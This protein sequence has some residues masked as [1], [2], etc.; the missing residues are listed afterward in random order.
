MRR[1]FSAF[2][3]V[4]KVWATRSQ[5]DGRS[6]NG[7]FFF[8]GDVAYSY[9]WSFPVAAMFDAP[10]GRTFCLVETDAPSTS[11]AA[12]RSLAAGAAK[13]AGCVMIHL[14]SIG[15]FVE[16]FSRPKREIGVKAL[17]AI[18]SLIERKVTDIE[19]I[20]ERSADNT[21]A[22]YD[23]LSTVA[24]LLRVHRDLADT[25]GVDWPS[26][27]SA[28]AYEARAEM[29]YQV[30]TKAAQAKHREVE[31]SRK[32]A[33]RRRVWEKN[34]PLPAAQELA[35]WRTG[36]RRTLQHQQD[37]G[38]HAESPVRARIVEGRF[39][40]DHGWSRPLKDFSKL[41]SAAVAAAAD[42]D[43][44]PGRLRIGGDNLEIHN[45]GDVALGWRSVLHF[46]ELMTCA[47]I[48]APRLHTKALAAIAE[49]A[50]EEAAP[51]GL[52]P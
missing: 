3:E 37:P 30:S 16:T 29:A 48:G 34:H 33:E 11:T 7:S 27:A 52:A 46:D 49:A 45:N 10:D 50:G 9:R 6:G 4:A 21:W 47:A 18:R 32:A 22:Q 19:A 28:E 35:L 43:G 20:A 39:T 42:H 44:A 14:P 2:E 26:P 51:A 5:E 38:P 1:V 36:E 13:E 15:S 23:R 40:T 41:F 8:E 17:N 25:F 24:R 31:K 12:V